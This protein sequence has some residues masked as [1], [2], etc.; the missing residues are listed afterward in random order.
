MLPYLLSVVNENA[1]PPFAAS[2]KIG[3]CDPA[4]KLKKNF[5]K[6]IFQKIYNDLT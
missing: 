6:I 4:L 1:G 5:K 3:I 2:D